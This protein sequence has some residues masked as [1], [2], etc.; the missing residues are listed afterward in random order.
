MG[1][2]QKGQSGNPGGRPKEIGHV[3]DL[4]QAHTENSIETLAEIRDNKKAAAAAR[5]VAGVSG[6]AGLGSTVHSS[7]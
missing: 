3:R 7:T 2:F 4:A 1:K 5:E 6:K